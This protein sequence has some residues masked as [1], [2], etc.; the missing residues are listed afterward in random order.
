MS[1]LS[2]GRASL[3]F[4]SLGNSTIALAIASKYVSQR[5]QFSNP[6]NQANG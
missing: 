2:S 3:A 5:R 6:N 1:P 4:S